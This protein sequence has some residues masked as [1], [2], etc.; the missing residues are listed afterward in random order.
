MATT[1]YAI[2]RANTHR[3]CCSS[4]IMFGGRDAFVSS[5]TALPTIA[6]DL[7]ASAAQSWRSSLLILSVMQNWSS[8]CTGSV[9]STVRSADRCSA[10]WGFNARIPAGVGSGPSPARESELRASRRASRREHATAGARHNSCPVFRRRGGE[11]RDLWR[12]ARA[13]W[14]GRLPGWRPL[15]WLDVAGLGWRSVFFVNVPIGL[16]IAAAGWG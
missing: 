6:V 5:L 15:V 12:G 13:R 3:L 7:R 4:A 16:A 14:R 9:T 10:S 8:P 1:C 11:H 2:P